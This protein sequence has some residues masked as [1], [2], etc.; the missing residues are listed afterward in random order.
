M[1]WLNSYKD[2]YSTNF[3]VYEHFIDKLSVIL[4]L[5]LSDNTIIFIFSHPCFLFQT[6]TMISISSFYS[7]FSDTLKIST[8]LISVR[9]PKN[10]LVFTIPLLGITF[11]LLCWFSITVHVFTLHNYRVNRN[12]SNRF[13]IKYLALYIDTKHFHERMCSMEWAHEVVQLFKISEMVQGM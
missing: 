3:L 9:I 1:P 6:F 12:A 4:V 2:V 7:I 13:M 11:T 8:Q 5:H 10:H